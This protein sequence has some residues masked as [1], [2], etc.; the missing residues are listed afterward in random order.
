MYGFHS[1]DGKSTKHPYLNRTREH[2]GRS[3]SSLSR[4]ATAGPPPGLFRNSS[5]VRKVGTHRDLA[6]LVGLSGLCRMLCRSLWGTPFSPLAPVNLK[7]SSTPENESQLASIEEL[8]S[9]TF[10]NLASRISFLPPPSKPTTDFEAQRMHVWFCFVYVFI[11][12]KLDAEVTRL[13]SKCQ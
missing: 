11:D 5:I 6:Q 7:V 3:K 12:Q 9:S 8:F 4:E 13:K 10:E 1:R 2:S